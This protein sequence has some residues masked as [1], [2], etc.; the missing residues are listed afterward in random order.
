MVFV[1][2]DTGFEDPFSQELNWI[3]DL[4]GSSC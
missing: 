4:V 3:Y 2:V 1:E